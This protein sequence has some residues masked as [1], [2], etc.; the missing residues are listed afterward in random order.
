VCRVDP[1]FAYRLPVQK[2]GIS[3]CTNP[4]P[5]RLIPEERVPGFI[6]GPGRLH[7]KS[8]NVL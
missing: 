5:F 8:Q 7:G 4:E 6:P 3:E 2:P 1:N